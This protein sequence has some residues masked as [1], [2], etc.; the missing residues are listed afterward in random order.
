MF[1]SHL[2]L[3][4]NPLV[5]NMA[6]FVIFEVLYQITNSILINR[7]SLKLVSGVAN[8]DTIYRAHVSSYVA[9]FD[10][11]STGKAP[12]PPNPRGNCQISSRLHLNGCACSYRI[13]IKFHEVQETIPAV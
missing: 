10:W 6:E 9:K 3:L 5:P 4:F 11:T 8:G 12:P 7:L 13:P 1:G 2:L